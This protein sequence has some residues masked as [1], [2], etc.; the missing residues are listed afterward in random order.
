MLIYIN[1]RKLYFSFVPKKT[2]IFIVNS[3]IILY[4]VLILVQLK[5]SDLTEEQ[6][7]KEKEKLIE[8]WKN[9]NKNKINVTTLLLQVWDGDSN[10]ITEKGHT[11]TLIGDGYV[12]EE[13]LGCR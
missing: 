11:E 6:L 13:I 7:V 2:N 5:A 12:Y 4:I 9:Q 1:L 10:G 8:Y 3:L